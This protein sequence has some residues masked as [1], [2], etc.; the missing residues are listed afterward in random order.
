MAA[1]QYL[2]IATRTLQAIENSQLGKI[3]D[4]ADLITASIVNDGSVFAF[5]ASHSFMIAEEMVY[6]T[7]GLMLVN[8]IYP[9]GMNMSV[10]PMTM[11][12]KLERIPGLGTELLASSPAKEGDALI[13]VSNSGRNAVTIDMALLARE[14]KIKTVVITALSYSDKVGSRHPSGKKLSDLC[15]VVIDN[16]VP[17][18]DAA[19]EISGFPQK[20]SPLSSVAGCA[21]VNAIAAEI[22]QMLVKR[23]VKPPVF[24]SANLDGGDEYNS[25]LLKENRHRIHYM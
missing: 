10:R 25:K 6:R 18:G 22:V 13:I 2:K 7:G 19:V 21:I 5:G 15:D 11:T 9:H 12:S 8:P 1:E 14:R 16:C 3:T 24:L 20:V 23:G 17:Y 4:A